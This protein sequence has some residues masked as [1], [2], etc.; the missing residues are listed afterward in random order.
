MRKGGRGVGANLFPEQLDD[1]Q[2]TLSLEG[3]RVGL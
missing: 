2:K 1:P 3:V